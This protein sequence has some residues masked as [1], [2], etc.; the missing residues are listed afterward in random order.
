VPAF[1][2]RAWTAVRRRRELTRGW[3][4]LHTAE[5]A[6]CVR[7]VL[8]IPAI[9]LGLRTIGFNRTRGLLAAVSRLGAGSSAAADAPVRALALARRY[10]PYRGNCLPQSLAL[11]SRLRTLGVDAELCLG[12][13]L[14]QGVFGAHAW[15]ESG[16]RPLND[17]PTVRTR[18]SAFQP[19]V[20]SST[21]PVT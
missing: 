13:S 11:W 21:D 2:R 12:A 6:E 14:D 9:A 7:F 3:R 5:R 10:A 19:A 1:A 20:S 8:L 18:F 4:R 17:S 16:G 15:V